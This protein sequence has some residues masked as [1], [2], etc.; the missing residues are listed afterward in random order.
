MEYCVAR[1]VDVLIHM[2][3]ALYQLE[4]PHHHALRAQPTINRNWPG[5]GKGT[6]ST[7][8]KS[9][10]HRLRHRYLLGSSVGAEPGAHESEA[11][12]SIFCSQR[13]EQT[14]VQGRSVGQGPE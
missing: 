9:S 1:T 8:L 11:V 2:V 7:S 4:C 13:R 14:A 5:D 3:V 6:H 12:S 10:L